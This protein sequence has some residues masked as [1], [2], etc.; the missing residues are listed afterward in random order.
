[1]S[2]STSKSTAF[3]PIAPTKTRLSGFEY[4][5]FP[6]DNKLDPIPAVSEPVFIS[7][8]GT[9]T[10]AGIS[11]YTTP[12]IPPKKYLTQTLDG[13]LNNCQFTSGTCAT[14]NGFAGQTFNVMTGAYS[15][16]AT[17]LAI[18]NTQNRAFW[19]AVPNGTATCT[20]AIF[21]SNTALASQPNWAL[22]MSPTVSEN[23]T[24]VLSQTTD[25]YTGTDVCGTGNKRRNG[26]V[27]A[28]LS[29]E[30]TEDTAIL[31]AAQVGPGSSPMASRET[32]GAGDF[33]FAWQN[34]T[35]VVSATGLSIG[36]QYRIA[37]AITT[38][39]YGGGNSVD[40]FQN[41]DFFAYAEFQEESIAIAC[42]PGKQ[43]TASTVTIE[44]I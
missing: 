18:T 36:N 11:E 38:E 31:R 9:A 39:D 10:L 24:R 7:Y 16:N 25:T 6:V 26:F 43:V 28:T 14:V 27:R 41:Y 13:T 34:S 22:G 21:S 37:I 5:A 12:S 2:F 23:T 29:D 40:G 44:R 3:S 4:Y 17:T 8:S 35:V 30:D 1:M 15:Y 33:S 20:N 42:D 19:A 32:R